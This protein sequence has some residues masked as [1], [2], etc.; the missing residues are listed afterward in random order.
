MEKINI[1]FHWNEILDTYHLFDGIV[2]K[3]RREWLIYHLYYELWYFCL[4]EI[5]WDMLTRVESNKPNS[6]PEKELDITLDYLYPLLKEWKLKVRI[7]EWFNSKKEVN[8]VLKD[9]IIKRQKQE[10]IKMLRD[11]KLDWNKRIVFVYNFTQEEYAEALQ[12]IKYKW[13]KIK[14]IHEK[15]VFISYYV[16]FTLLENNWIG[17][18]SWEYYVINRVKEEVQTTMI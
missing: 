9:I 10:I 3:K 11:E 16:E 18:N 12:F 15:A 17:Y 8:E 14:D 6:T 13:L 1:D 7:V 2:R 4:S 5:C